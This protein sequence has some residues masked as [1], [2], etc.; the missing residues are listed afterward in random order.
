MRLNTETR[1]KI[2]L[3]SPESQKCFV[4]FGYINELA[5]MNKQFAAPLALL[6]LAAMLPDDRYEKRLVDENTKSLTD[7]DILWSDMVFVSAMTVAAEGMERV[8]MRAKSLGRTTV[9]GGPHA[10]T[11]FNMVDADCLFLG[12]A[13]EMLPD[14]LED[15]E[16][17]TLKRAYAVP[18]SQAEQERLEAC[19]QED[20]LLKPIGSLPSLSFS[21]IPEYGLI[22]LDD[23]FFMLVQT[24]RGCPNRCDFCSICRRFGN[25][26]HKPVAQVVAELEALYRHG[27]RGPVFFADDN[28]IGDKQHAK[29]LMRA[30][31]KWQVEHKRVFTFA[32]EASIN[33]G[34]DV[35]LLDLLAAARVTNIYAGIESPVRENLSSS[36]KGVN[37]NGDLDTRIAAI[38][39][40]GFGIMG[41]I[42]VGFDTDPDDIGERIVDFIQ[43]NHIPTTLHNFLMALPNTKLYDRIESE[44]RLLNDP[45]DTGLHFSNNFETTRPMMDVIQSYRYIL[46]QLYPEDMQ[47]FFERCKA[48]TALRYST[49]RP[50]QEIV[51]EVAPGVEPL[52]QEKRP[53]PVQSVLKQTA[54]QYIKIL[55]N[56]LKDFP[57][58]KA[59]YAFYSWAQEEHPQKIDLALQLILVGHHYWKTTRAFLAA[60]GLWDLMKACME[61]FY[62]MQGRVIPRKDNPF[63][64]GYP[65][66]DSMDMPL[67]A[68]VLEKERKGI[69]SKVNR[70]YKQLNRFAQD[71]IHKEYAYFQR[72]MRPD[73]N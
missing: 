68:A 41:G 15:L 64:T 38:M 45:S 63:F 20:M 23:Y 70:A 26:R 58:A 61:E 10:R 37:L 22:N 53:T 16:T 31:T 7:A 52:V 14:F 72:M 11:E 18:C 30:I 43:R 5:G 62:A 28:T 36:N 69:L 17:G 60:S 13:E 6:T 42:I 29:E 44:G 66:T 54:A 2:L 47:S 8:L 12:E 39:G 56:I 49:R 3:V 67:G 34:D 50:L 21:P 71:Y 48:Y 1:T 32:M 33:M 55:A 40:H 65:D 73:S 25:I 4:N 19:F 51:A 27:W 59:A 57:Y 35:E 9:A 46:T 24:S